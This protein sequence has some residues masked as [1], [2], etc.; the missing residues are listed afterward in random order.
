[1]DSSLKVDRA[2][3][4]CEAALHFFFSVL[5]A[6]ANGVGHLGKEPEIAN[7]CCCK[8]WIIHL[9]LLLFKRGEF[10]RLEEWIGC[11]RVCISC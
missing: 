9:E 8:T 10:I 3:H 11:P 1:M 4:G 2:W 5:L 6:H 7:L